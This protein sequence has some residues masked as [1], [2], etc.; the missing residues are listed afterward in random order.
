MESGQSPRA[1]ASGRARSA[2]SRPTAPKWPRIVRRF[3]FSITVS[4]LVEV[5]ITQLP[6]TPRGVGGDLLGFALPRRSRLATTGRA[7]NAANA[8]SSSEWL[9]I[10]AP[11]RRAPRPGRSSCRRM[12][13]PAVRPACSPAVC[14]PGTRAA[15]PVLAGEHAACEREVRKERQVRAPA[16]FEHAVLFGCAAQQAVLVL[17]RHVSARVPSYGCVASASA[18]ISAEKLLQPISRTL[19]ARTSASSAP[20]VSSGAVVGVREV[21]LVQIDA[22]RAEALQRI[23]ARPLD[24]GGGRAALAVVVDRASELGRDQRVSSRREPSARPRNSS[25]SVPP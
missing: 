24:V 14:R 5:G 2:D 22:V 16:R 25:L 10:T 11:R 12:P 19:P 20:S 15:A 7:S 9:A 23:V 4:I 3:A 18:S 6:R 17:H 8:S 13:A 21:Q 1:G